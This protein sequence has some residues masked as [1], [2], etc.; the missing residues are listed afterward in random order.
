MISHKV[1]LALTAV[2]F[3]FMTILYQY[4]N[5]QIRDIHGGFKHKHW[6]CPYPKGYGS[7]TAFSESML[8]SIGFRTK[9]LIA[10]FRL[11]FFFLIKFLFF[12]FK[13]K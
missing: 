13:L 8:F 5:I 2:F 10:H 1:F 9:C 12:N 3:D 11:Y 6:G 7:Q 4:F